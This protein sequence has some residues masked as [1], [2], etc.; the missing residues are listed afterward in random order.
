[1]SE[2]KSEHA[3][4]SLL[5]DTARLDESYWQRAEHLAIRVAGVLLVAKLVLSI[6]HH[7]QPQPHGKFGIL[8]LAALMILAIL[9]AHTR[10]FATVVKQGLVHK[11]YNHLSLVS[12][13]NRSEELIDQLASLSRQARTSVLASIQ[14]ERDFL[15][16]KLTFLVGSL[17]KTGIISSFLMLFVTASRFSGADHQ[18]TAALDAFDYGLIAVLALYYIGVAATS[19]MGRLDS[20]EDVLKSSLEREP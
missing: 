10:F 13:A 3:V 1:M 17:E 15:R 19:V 16:G 8:V 6:V 7:V 18:R 11:R 9:L 4:L 5:Q 12:S 14:R 2:D 20:Y